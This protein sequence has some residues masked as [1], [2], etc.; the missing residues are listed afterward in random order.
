M[1]SSP[2]DSDGK[3]SVEIAVLNLLGHAV[4]KFLPRTAF[5]G[6]TVTDYPSQFT[7]MFLLP[8]DGVLPE[9]DSKPSCFN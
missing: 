6:G 3:A 9:S 8:D 4:V 2:G 7:V 5:G 1:V